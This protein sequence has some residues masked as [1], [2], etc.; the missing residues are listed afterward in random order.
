MRFQDSEAVE[1]LEEQ[2]IEILQYLESDL[3]ANW[4]EKAIE[5]RE[6]FAVIYA[7]SSLFRP[8]TNPAAGPPS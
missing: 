2:E 7:R 6:P 3:A 8:S 4:Y 5:T 1:D